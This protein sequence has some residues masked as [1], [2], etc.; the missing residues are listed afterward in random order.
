MGGA[1]KGDYVIKLTREGTS[2]EFENVKEL[3]LYEGLAK[4][5]GRKS[6]A[7]GVQCPRCKTVNTVKRGFR[8]IKDGS[9][10]SS[11]QRYYCK[12]C[13]KR[14][15]LNPHSKRKVTLDVQKLISSLRKE[16]LS[17]R[18]I[19]KHLQATQ[20]LHISHATVIRNLK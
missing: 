13:D 11:T 1:R 14:F 4:Y 8:I 18:R 3:L 5:R 17:A 16:G 19:A 12:N 20:G 7:D 15:V 6:S 9:N 2:Y 10:S